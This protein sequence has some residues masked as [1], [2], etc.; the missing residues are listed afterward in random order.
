[1]C[2]CVCVGVCADPASARAAVICR[3]REAARRQAQA[4]RQSLDQAMREL[5][6]MNEASLLEEIIYHTGFTLGQT[7]NGKKSTLFPI[8]Y[9]SQSSALFYV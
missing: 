4:L 2:V 8:S 3:E 5:K 1:M 9:L 7:H 6:S